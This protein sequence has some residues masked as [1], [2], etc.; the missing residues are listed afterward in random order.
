MHLLEHLKLFGQDQ[1][2]LQKA[3]K[4]NRMESMKNA[5]SQFFYRTMKKPFFGRFMVPWKSPLTFSDQG[6]WNKKIVDS[7][8]GGRLTLWTRETREKPRAVI[9]LGHPMGKE[10][11][12]FFLKNGLAEFY[13]SL[14]F[15][16]AVFDFN[17]FG[18][19]SNGDFLY[20]QDVSAVSQKLK[21]MYSQ[22]PLLYHG[23]SLGG[24]WAT[25]ALSLE[26]NPIS[27]AIIENAAPTLEQ[28]WIR[29][30]AAY[31]SLRIIYTFMPRLAKD[32]RMVDR[33]K[34]TKN[35]KRI[36]FIYS[37]ADDWTPPEMG[38]EFARASNA[39]NELWIMK[40]AKHS[41]AMKSTERD[42]Y[43]AKIS[44]FLNES[45]SLAAE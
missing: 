3:S 11:K 17:G 18:E 35:V 6:D 28:F 16:V 43:L 31:V 21:S 12:G 20:F 25:I 8:S 22:L 33:I 36:L 44:S 19:S 15:N 30:P 26:A 23:V 5:A 41:L 42:D 45:L 7:Q 29:F 2:Y 14:G 38:E 40:T 32:V 13:L 9:L 37:E 39:P 10:A 24:Q 1:F 27:L 34:Q 4:Y